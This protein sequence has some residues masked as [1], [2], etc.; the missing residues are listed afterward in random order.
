M[1]IEKFEISQNKNDDSIKT[2]QYNSTSVFSRERQNRAIFCLYRLYN[3]VP[4][5]LRDRPFNTQSRRQGTK[6]SHLA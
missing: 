4:R 5:L 1:G 3:T 6:A 2:W